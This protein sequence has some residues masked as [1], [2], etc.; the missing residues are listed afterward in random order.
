MSEAAAL[1]HAAR[2]LQ[3]IDEGRIRTPGSACAKGF[4]ITMASS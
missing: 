2:A 1:G 4:W 3:L